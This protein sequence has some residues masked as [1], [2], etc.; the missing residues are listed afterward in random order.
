VSAATPFEAGG[1]LP[2]TGFEAGPMALLALLLLLTYR[3]PVLWIVPLFVVGVADQL[4]ARLTTVVS[5]ITDQP[6]NASSAG[7][8]S[9]LVF[10]A[11]T[12]Y[13]LLL[14]ARY[15]ENLRHE[16][17][18]RVALREAVSSAGGAIVG[19]AVTVTL[20][21]LTLLLAVSGSLRTIGW[22]SAVGVVVVLVSVI[23]V[24]PAA[25]ALCGRRLFWPFIPRV[26]TDD[27]SH[28]GV[29]AKV[30]GA[31]SRRPALVSAGAV[32]ILLVFASGIAG[33]RIGLSQTEQFR[34]ASE[35]ATG[36]ENIAAHYPAG[37]SAPAQVIA[38]SS[39]EQAVLAAATA[40]AGVDSARVSDRGGD[41]VQ[42]SAVP[43]DLPGTRGSYATVDAL[44][45]S[46]HAVDGADALVGG[47]V[48]D[49]LD[50]KN[51]AVRDQAVIAPLILL[52]VLA[53]L[54]LLLRSL[55]APALLILTVVLSCAAAIGAG[56]WSDGLGSRIEPL[57]RLALAVTVTLVLVA[58]LDH[59]TTWALPH[60]PG[61]SGGHPQRHAGGR[62][63][64]GR[65]DRRGD[66]QRRRPARR[67]VHR[68][69]GPAPHHPHPD[70]D[71]RRLRRPARH[72][73]RA[74]GA[75]PGPHHPART[76]GVVA[77]PDEPRRGRGR[78]QGRGS[79]RGRG[80]S[81]GQDRTA[82]M[83]SCACAP[84]TCPPPRST[85]SPS[86]TWP[87]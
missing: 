87:R 65:G 16:E 42:I 56:H 30:A 85:S 84:T 31:V 49:T 2:A 55:V 81:Q 48:A 24:M 50:A 67:S 7:I 3:S 12:N 29:W 83:R 73:P 26:G 72:A 57:R 68:A 9:V 44:R 77:E 18:H 58:A 23:V 25:L 20:S 1:E 37:A 10:G 22:T 5:A 86:A 64:R 17:D 19:S 62:P 15:R 78:A 43:K 28:Q 63:H 75:R 8:A 70:R 11:G 45:A 34:G 39:A 27:P 32:V 61:A 33:A 59:A 14:I 4:G 53:I 80:R 21:L 69:R 46:V 74:D 38:R 76:Q 13:A 52:V 41:L 40:T 47:S 66:H 79:G 6:T 60:H 82:T 36:L 54:V 71:H 35:S 51:A